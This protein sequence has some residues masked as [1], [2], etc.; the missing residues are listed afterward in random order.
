MNNI[1]TF[2]LTVFLLLIQIFSIKTWL[3][4]RDFV[5]SYH[6]S[7]YDLILQIDDAVRSNE[8]VPAFLIK[9]FHNKALQFVIDMYKRY[10]HFFDWQ[11]LITLISVVGVFG[12]IMG[13]WYFVDSKKKNKFIGFLI[14]AMFLIPFIEIL[15]APNINFYLKLFFITVPFQAVS[16]YGHFQFLTKH[17]SLLT[18]F[19]YIALIVLSIAWMTFIPNQAF[20]YCGRI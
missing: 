3:M 18:L 11:L 19:I 7:L 4:C 1:K 15:I 17:K 10:T 5:D 8:G 14:L 6:F 20:N 2:L 13:I 12:V 9:V 16:I